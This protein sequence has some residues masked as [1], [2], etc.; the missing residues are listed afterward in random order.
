MAP[1]VIL[2]PT[3]AVYYSIKRYGL[4]SSNDSEQKELI[5]TGKTRMVLYRYLSTAY[6]AGAIICFL[7]YYL[8]HMI[9]GEGNLS[10]TIYTSVIFMLF[11][12]AILI[13][14]IVIK[15]VAY[16]GCISFVSVLISIP[17]IT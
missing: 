17:V 7:P 13:F 6:V 2:I 12:I 16:N 4:F 3:S 9:Y 14:Q 15:N 10:N 5:L 11:G 1:V 8:P